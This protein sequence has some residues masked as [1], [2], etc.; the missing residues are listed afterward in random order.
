MSLC[1][2]DNKKHFQIQLADTPFVGKWLEKYQGKKFKTS[3]RFPGSPDHK[4][5]YEILKKNESLFNKFK[6]Y[7]LCVSSANE[8]YKRSRLS[9]IH[10]AIVIF[11][12]EFR[13]STNLMNQNTNG[14]W[15]EI[16]ELLHNLENHIRTG[17]KEFVCGDDGL[18]HD[19]NSHAQNW[20]WDP[21]LSHDEYHQSAS[22]DI[23]HIN[24]PTNELGRHPYE[25]FLHSPD[26][27][28]Q[29]GSMLGQIHNRLKAGLARIFPQPDKNYAEWCGIQG[30]PVVG[31]NFPLA[32]FKNEQ[33]ALEILDS[34]ELEIQA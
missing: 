5:L 28:E 14:E 13:K 33:D 3:V 4:K 34:S 30:L 19:S 22:F 15:D 11:Q 18:Q 2:I 9:Q 7:D 32:N 21:I 23:W 31:N 26:T 29:E 17:N 1:I 12:K 20:S 27:W 6:L 24:V 8:L 16:H 25:C 10:L